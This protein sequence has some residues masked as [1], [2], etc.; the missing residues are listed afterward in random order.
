MERQAPF[1]SGRLSGT[2]D[3]VQRTAPINHPDWSSVIACL[4]ERE[5]RRIIG[6]QQLFEKCLLVGCRVDRIPTAV[7]KPERQLGLEGR[8]FGKVWI[9]NAAQDHHPLQALDAICV[10]A[11]APADLAAHR[12]TCQDDWLAA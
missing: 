7:R 8:T 3:P 12:R 6:L 11:H 9:G 5:M 2:Q 10:A 1:Q 4:V